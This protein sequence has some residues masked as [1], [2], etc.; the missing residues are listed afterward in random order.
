[1]TR[2]HLIRFT[3]AALL[4]MTV[5]VAQATE[6]EWITASN[7]N[8]QLLLQVNARYSPESA[9]RYGLPEYDAGVLDLKPGVVERLNTDLQQALQ[10]IREKRAGTT[11][12]LVA[13]DLDILL[14]AA[15]D[16]LDQS[17]LEDRLLLPYFD[18]PER[19]FEGFAALLDERTAKD[20]QQA[21]LVRLK[22]Y[23]GNAPGYEPIAALARARI[24]ERLGDTSL[25]A[26]W[27]NEVEQD[28]SNQQRYLDGIRDLFRNSGLKG[29]NGDY[30]R[31]RKQLDAYAQWIRSTV[32]PKT[33]PDHRLPAEIYA[34]RLRGYGVDASPE[35]LIR[36]GL[37]AW[38][39]A[40]SEI[41][42]LARIVAREQNLPSSNYR[43][44]L[45]ALKT[46]QITNEQVLPLYR[47][48][49]QEIEAIVRRENIVTLPQRPPVVR[50]GTEAESAASPAP[51]IDLPRLIGNT[52][53]PAQFVLPLTNPNARPGTLMDDFTY[54]AGS[55]TL[56]VHE[57][58]PG[59]DL[60]IATALENGISTTRT[61]FA[62]N[63][64]NLEGWALYA[65]GIMKPYL[66]VA[67][68]MA[69]LQHRMMRAA[70]AFLDPMLNLGRIDPQTAKRILMDD[71][72]LS[73]P[74]ATQEVDRY[75]LRTPGQA[76]AYLY[77]YSR[78]MELRA[79]TELALGDRF[80]QRSYHDFLLAQGWLPLA[81][82]ES[83]VTEGYVK[84]HL[85]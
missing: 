68:Q 46:K 23:A 13:Q 61:I 34:Q 71:V 77:G 17:Q 74:M 31:L 52:G 20:R 76:T 32:L 12:Q 59:H 39:Q 81:L 48:R 58:R 42:A 41:E 40:R 75:T 24:E 18:L 37:N 79:R 15:Q 25:T 26:P 62:F 11:D 51:H 78:L 69:S 9:A 6:P 2:Q 56:A 8:A 1:M 35:E 70:R 10:Q 36:L 85:K 65:E 64:A 44:V 45:R 72:V 29:W 28:L 67:A 7:L 84:Q 82:L 49:L 53:E 19:I 30:G 38:M 73:E 33:R 4:A 57:S 21:A 83:A 54:D 66:P 3:A 63:S 22:R 5:A 14:K 27:R 55:W 47:S 60:Q 80:E 43:D 50:L 16:E